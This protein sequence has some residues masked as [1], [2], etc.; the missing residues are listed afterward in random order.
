MD[1]ISDQNLPHWNG[2]SDE[3]SSF[4]TSYLANLFYTTWVG[5]S[6]A[7]HI[8]YARWVVQWNVMSNT[9]SEQYKNFQAWYRD[10]KNILGLTPEIAIANYEGALPSSASEYR[11]QLVS[12]LAS[13]PVSYV[14][15]WNEPNHEGVSASAAAS[16]WKEANAVCQERGCTAIAG[17][18]LDE[19]HPEEHLVGYEKEYVTALKGA[20]PENWGVHPYAAIKYRTK[21]PVEAFKD[22]LPSSSD[23]IW[24][25]E[26]GAYLCQVGVGESTEIEQRE[27]AEYLVNK[28]IPAFSPAHTFY[29]YFMY[30]WNEETPCSKYTNSS[31][32][33]LHNNA[34]TAA[35][36]VF[37]GS[38]PTPAAPT[39][40][41]SAASGI[42]EERVTLNG[43][44]NPN[45]S[46]THYYF[47]YG[48]TTSY[49]SDTV[50]GNA[51]AGTSTVP[52]S[53]TATDLEEGA[54][55]HYRLVAESY[56]GTSYGSDQTVTTAGYP[57]T[58]F[59]AGWYEP[60]RSMSVGL[61][62]QL[63][64]ACA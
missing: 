10:V 61:P 46:I 33:N 6:P 15:A 4:K 36:I 5:G 35:S 17:D 58:V 47:Q 16:Y 20:N 55:C 56:W 50:I 24:F 18:L 52:V 2:A 29:Y 63:A 25:T 14:E 43:D 53:A 39:V 11:A 21:T 51:G 7:T 62:S 59:Y 23:H 64:S 42:R 38:I 54:A 3:E 31:L 8:K 49:G 28:L 41:T 9:G 57:I 12:I 27:G 45:A 13:F 60:R 22:N 48:P 44:V 40:S 32:Y 30:G 26:A 1:G 37:G 34:R 19:L